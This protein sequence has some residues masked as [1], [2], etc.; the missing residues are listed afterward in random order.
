M[1]RLDEEDLDIVSRTGVAVITCPQSNLRLASGRCPMTQLIERDVPL[2]LGTDGAASVGALD[3]LAESRT[4]A[5]LAPELGS[6]QVLKLAT[7]GGAATLGIA[8]TIGSLEPGKAADFICVD[9]ESLA[10]QSEAS[11]TDSIVYCATRH[12]VSD[13]WIGGRRAV[14]DGTLMTFDEPQLMRVAREWAGR[15]HESRA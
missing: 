4:A 13:V 6:A 9:L 12:Q 10:C 14:A 1:N 5:L 2:G 3:L 11:V 15:I 7:M 8:G